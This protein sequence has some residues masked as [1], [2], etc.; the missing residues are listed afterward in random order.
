MKRKLWKWVA[1]AATGSVCFW[2]AGCGQ[3]D[4]ETGS[5]SW[6]ESADSQEQAVN[7]KP[8]QKNAEDEEEKN[9]VEEKNKKA[10]EAYA[11]ALRAILND[12]VWPDGTEISDDYRPFGSDTEFEQN[13]F[14]IC[15]V[16]SDGKEELLISITTS[17]MAGMFQEVYG[18][19]EETDSLRSELKEF[20]SLTYYDNGTA[21]A[22]WS[23]NQGYGM[24]LWPYNLYVYDEAADSYQYEGAADSWD[25]DNVPDGF[26]A[27]ADTDGDG[28]IYYLYEKGGDGKY[29][30]IDGAE[31]HK[32]LDPY[33]N[34]AKEIQIPWQGISM[35]EIETVES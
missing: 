26:P 31:Y 6:K 23:H 4:A 19:E 3:K 17:S 1:V 22:E 20:P 18:Y 11:E 32:W 10:R 16:D 5:I 8:E 33:M 29:K 13:Q 25:K 24:K 14:A 7:T 30:T 28:T 9:N 21:K 2:M 35:T 34:G 15:D 12:N 27:D